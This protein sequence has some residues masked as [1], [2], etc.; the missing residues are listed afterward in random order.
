MLTGPE[1]TFTSC[2]VKPTEL[3]TSTSPADA[4]IVNLP[5]SS[6]TEERLVF[7]TVIVAPVAGAAVRSLII[8]PLTFAVCAKACVLARNTATRPHSSSGVKRIVWDF[9]IFKCLSSFKFLQ[10]LF[11]LHRIFL[12]HSLYRVQEFL[13]VRV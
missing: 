3:M 1:P 6:A 13:F 2:E 12:Y 10:R 5:A 4:S 7:F 11:F 8:V 9:F